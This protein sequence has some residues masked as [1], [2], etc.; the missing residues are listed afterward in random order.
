M[1][2]VRKIASFKIALVGVD[3]FKVEET[4]LVMNEVRTRVPYRNVKLDYA[5]AS[6]MTTTTNLPAQQYDLF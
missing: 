5:I 1:K 3:I 4:A 6:M 2:F